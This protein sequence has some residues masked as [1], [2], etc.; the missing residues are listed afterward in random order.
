M[1]SEACRAVR[2]CSASPDRR[3][4]SPRSPG[5]GEAQALL[6]GAC[7]LCRR[8]CLVDR[9]LHLELRGRR[10]GAPDRPGRAEQ[11]AVGGDGAQVGPGGDEGAGVL[12]RRHDDDVGERARERGPQGRRGRDEVDRPDGVG[13]EVG[14]LRQAVVGGGDHQPRAAGVVGLE[15]GERRRCVGG[16]GHRHGVGRC[17]EGGCDGLLRAGPH[18]DQG[19]ERAEHAVL[20]GA[21]QRRGA[22]AGQ[23]ELERL[24]ARRPRAPL[25]LGGALGGLQGGQ[26]LAGVVERGDRLLVAFV[27]VLLAGVEPAGLLLERGELGLRA[28]APESR[29]VQRAG[30]A[31]ELGLRGSGPRAECAHLAGEPREAL[32]PVGDGA[33][34]DDQRPFLRG[35]R[36]LGV[37]ARGDGVD[38]APAVGLELRGQLG[39]LRPHRLRLALDLLRV[40]TGPELLRQRSGEVAVPLGGQRSRAAQPLVE[41]RQPVPGLLRPGERRRLRRDGLLELGLARRRAGELALH[42]R[43]PLAHGRLV[44]HLGLERGPQSDEV[45]GEQA[46]AGVAQVGLHLGGAAGDLRLAAERLELAAQLGGEVLQPR[47]VGLH[48]VELA[49]RLL[50]ALA[51]LQDARGLLDEPP[52]VLRARLQHR[53]ELALADDDVQLA[54]DAAVA[55]Q[56]LHVDEPAAA[57]VDRVLRRAIAEHQPGDADLGV[58]D[59]QHAVGVVDRE[60]HLG[61]AERRARGRPG[62][63]DV[64]HLAA[65]QRLGPLLAEHPRDRVDDVALAR[66][67]RP[68]DAR[69]PRLEAQGRR[70]R[71]GLEALE[72]EALEVHAVALGRVRGSRSRQ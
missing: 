62:E 36:G 57:A 16:R 29:V 26:A 2:D 49:Q 9:C 59:R 32:P 7:G 12:E 60:R 39:L 31:T 47:E 72:R 56:L 63:D 46:Q 22:V 10:R 11:V 4:T 71:E 53:V 15:P 61:P 13:G 1:A 41:G 69:D 5:E 55:Q 43:P 28:L 33:A 25:A 44:A 54:A 35:E 67:V 42:E 70:R 64:L 6:L 34:G 18:G 68:D 52:P 51:V 3:S 48:R 30:E 8:G 17:T 27:E 24:A 21:G 65:A 20:P 50:L 58:V 14:A 66:P 23:R 45:V 19:G 37:G 40:A 38:E